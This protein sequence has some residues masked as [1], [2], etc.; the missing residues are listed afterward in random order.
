MAIFVHTGRKARDGV[1]TESVESIMKPSNSQTY[2]E[3]EK[4]QTP[5]FEPNRIEVSVGTLIKSGL[6]LLTTSNH[7]MIS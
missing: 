5:I 6:H 3:V 7:S 4:I 1:W 2:Q